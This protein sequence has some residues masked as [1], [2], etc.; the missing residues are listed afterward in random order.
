MQKEL[1]REDVLEVPQEKKTNKKLILFILV[2]IIVVVLAVLAI[3]GYVYLT[4]NNI[5]PANLT[6]NDSGINNTGN[7][8]PVPNNT[9][10]NVNGTPRN[11]TV[12]NRSSSGGG[13]GDGGGGDGGCIAKS[14]SE[15]GYQCGNNTN[16][17][18]NAVNC[19][20]CSSGFSCGNNLCINISCNVTN[21]TYSFS[22]YNGEA[23]WRNNCGGL[24]SLKEDCADGCS[25][26]ICIAPACTND[27]GCT[28]I[29]GF[30]QGLMPYT[31]AN[32]D[33]DSC[34]DR[35]NGTA[36]SGGYI[37]SGGSCVNESVIRDT[38]FTFV[39]YGDSRTGDS[40]HRAIVNLTQKI[41]PAFVLHTGDFVG[42]GSSATEWDTF[43]QIAAPL[44][45]QA[46][47]PGLTSYFYPSFGNHETNA[48]Q[49]G[50]DMYFSVFNHTPINQ[51]YYS[52]DYKNAHFISLYVTNT[53]APE[54]F[55]PG[56]AQ[57]QWIVNDLQ[58]ADSNSSIKWKFV[59]FHAPV[60]SCISSHACGPDIQRYLM[61]LFDEYGVTAVF[62]G[63]DHSYQ[64]IGPLT[65]YT[66][67]Q[68]GTTYIITA[69]A[70]AGLY[71]FYST[72]DCNLHEGDVDMPCDKWPEDMFPGQPHTAVPPASA[73]KANH[74][75]VLNVTYNAVYGQ[76]INL[77]GDV[78]DSFTLVTQQSACGNNI[79]E[80]GE[81]C[82]GSDFGS[83]GNGV[84]KCA[85]YDSQFI[86]GNLVC[87]S[88]QIKTSQCAR[89]VCGNG[90]K[91]ASEQCDASDF[92][93]YGNGV[94][95]CSQYNNIYSSGNLA[96]PGCIIGTNNCI[97]GVCGDSKIN[98]GEE[99]DDGN[100]INGDGCNS[101]CKI[102][103]SSRTIYVDRN[104]AGRCLTYNPSARTCSGGTSL[105]F[106]N[107]SAA[108]DN[109]TAGN[110]VMIRAGTYNEIFKPV[111]SGIRSGPITFKN[112]PGEGVVITGT[113]YDERASLCPN[114]PNIY[115]G[116]IWM[117]YVNYIVIDGLNFSNYE[118]FGRIV[119][120][121]NNTFKNCNF[122]RTNA[123]WIIGLHLFESH[124]N[125]FENN[126]FEGASDNFRIVHS[127]RNIIENNEFY[128]GDHVLLTLKCSS[129]NII[130][131]NYFYNENQKAMEVLDCEQPTMIDD[132]NLYCQD[133]AIVDSAKY[134]LIENNTFAYTA[135]DRLTDGYPDGPFSGIQ[136][137]AQNGIIRK[138]VFY[139]NNGGGIGM[140]NYEGEAE[141]TYGNRAY[142]NVF[143]KNRFAAIGVGGGTTY[144]FYDN[145]FKNNVLYKNDF[146]NWNG[147]YDQWGWTNANA[148]PFQ[149][150]TTTSGQGYVFERNNILNQSAGENH[151]IAHA[152]DYEYSDPANR[153]LAWWQQTHPSNFMNN[154]EVNPGFV[155][156]NT[157]NF[158]LQS[159]SQMIDVGT[160][161]TS[162]TSAG[163]GNIMQVSD[164][165]YFYDGYGIWGEQGDIM[166]LGSGGKARI[167]KIDYSTNTLTLNQ[168]LTWVNGHGVSLAYSGGKPDIGAYEYTGGIGGTSM[169]SEADKTE[170]SS[171]TL[172]AWLKGF[173]TAN[174]IKEI[175]GY[176][177]K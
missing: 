57:Y 102:E 168:S 177:W 25:Q 92:G 78:I 23:Y 165:G 142:S 64:R 47:S 154:L 104:L 76:A 1:K 112:Y 19:G 7:N 157:H 3:L 171:L 55:E 33:A 110:T 141:Y 67:N 164:A 63:D 60:F 127:E 163:S 93:I 4:G 122:Y 22:C 17:C 52:F 137:S 29:G 2:G 150:W 125:R 94:N 45:N 14:C 8:L 11:T 28:G 114:D 43:K 144:D 50:I 119:R 13:G 53:W 153:S 147:V 73:L 65:N 166:Q 91:E 37:C 30:C 86:S 113:A 10:T 116:P 107:I 98:P 151:I 49:A 15:L 68:Y 152:D 128:H 21:T 161:L 124:D 79:K 16:N 12:T 109:A 99:C 69:G 111:N 159:T 61:T 135:I 9:Q 36:C 170:V 35:A 82:D 155:N 97:L 130:R 42:T 96:C 85:D 115:Y 27:V 20:D 75:T 121:N 143:Y 172:W 131:N 136:Y 81:E 145:I 134:N 167:T 18:G 146:I 38:T 117:D 5:P 48:G 6:N 149:I 148:K 139:D 56:S 101:T 70:G 26:G 88:C 34:L 133:T 84:S 174:T 156:E 54:D 40:I 123:D 106:N 83:Y 100:L 140:G 169:K 66:Q 41:N 126:L 120:S 24:S 32:T 46:H 62:G 77:S 103:I 58:K 108:A 138:N 80:T 175:T 158:R 173:L 39:A 105:A 90:I 89:P 95:K 129:Y 71:D 160:F 72:T 74:F 176:F 31:C 51:S 162:T 87:Q 118:G 44:L 59:F 132:Y